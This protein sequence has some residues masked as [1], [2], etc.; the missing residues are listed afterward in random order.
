MKPP[1][2]IEQAALVG[3][4]P[5]NPDDDGRA[6]TTDTIRVPVHGTHVMLS[7]S[8]WARRIA[9]AV[10]QPGAELVVAFDG[11]D[12]YHLRTSPLYEDD[13]S[14]A[15][16]AITHETVWL[17]RERLDP[18]EGVALLDRLFVGSPVRFEIRGPGA[19]PPTD[20]LWDEASW[21]LTRFRQ[22]R[23]DADLL[24]LPGQTLSMSPTV[25]DAADPTR[26]RRPGREGTR[27]TPRPE[28][29][30][31]G[32]AWGL[33]REFWLGTNACGV[34]RAVFVAQRR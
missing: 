26:W 11:L 22:A 20:Q 14:H 19:A 17:M 7:S 4:P 10:C 3:A 2:D 25:P 24:F 27:G 15:I 29:P 34:C 21:L 12:G 18:V 1:A 31:C 28:C 13:L 30:V 9:E 8:E 5:A 23:P 6:G 33:V 32:D 16:A